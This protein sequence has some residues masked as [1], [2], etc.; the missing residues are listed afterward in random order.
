MDI[1]ALNDQISYLYCQSNYF[2]KLIKQNKLQ[3]E[4]IQNNILN[5]CDH[6]WEYMD[7]VNM[8]DKPDKIC[9]KCNS[10]KP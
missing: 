4:K 5:M 10:I 7:V 9:K 8:Y 3:I 2:E 1:K 6:D